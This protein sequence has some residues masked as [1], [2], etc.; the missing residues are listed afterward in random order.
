MDASQLVE[1]AAVVARHAPLVVNCPHLSSSGMRGYQAACNER[2]RRWRETLESLR[3]NA[4]DYPLEV[5]QPAE[6]NQSSLAATVREILL[7]DVL[8]RVWA[9]I[10]AAHDRRH[11]G[12]WEPIAGEVLAEHIALTNVALRIVLRG[13]QIWLRPAA[14]LNRLRR[15]LER[16]TDL[17][18]AFVPDRPST[19]AVCFSSLRVGQFAADWQ[20]LAPNI[21]YLAWGWTLGSLRAAIAPCQHPVT[22]PLCLL[23]ERVGAGVLAC[24]GSQ[25]FDDAG[26]LRPLWWAQLAGTIEDAQATTEELFADQNPSPTTC[27]DTPVADPTQ[28]NSPSQASQKTFPQYPKGPRFSW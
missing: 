1:L 6:P 16:W 9:G 23:N 4:A 26:G 14:E 5:V 22:G 2:A 21:R 18:L 13:P 10:V 27:R 11:A 12:H 3:Q 24:L 28:A 19:D 8:L 20:H 17:L 7:A 25:L 15:R